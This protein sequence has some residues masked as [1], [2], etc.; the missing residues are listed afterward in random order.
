M[1]SCRSPGLGSSAGEAAA[2]T[3]IKV[4]I[5]VQGSL[6]AKLVSPWCY[7]LLTPCQAS[8]AMAGMRRSLCLVKVLDLD[9]KP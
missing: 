1:H 2:D 8:G 3:H 9:P 4:C 5:G 7:P 6:L